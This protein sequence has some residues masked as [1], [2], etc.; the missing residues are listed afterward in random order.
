MIKSDARGRIPLFQIAAPVPSYT[1]IA[2]EWSRSGHRFARL[3][4]LAAAVELDVQWFARG[5]A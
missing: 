2:H 1:L 4:H 5:V 3:D